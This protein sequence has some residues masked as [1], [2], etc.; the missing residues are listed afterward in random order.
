VFAFDE[1]GYLGRVI[2][3]DLRYWVEGVPGRDFIEAYRR[4][5]RTIVT[6]RLNL[7]PE[8]AQK[9]YDFAVTNAREENKYYRYDYFLDNCSTRVRD[10]IDFALGGALRRATQG[11]IVPRT[12][13]SETLRLVDDMKVTQFAINAA[14]ASPTDNELSV[15]ENMFV[16][17]RLKDAVRELRITDASGALVPAVADEQVLHE[18]QQHDERADAPSLWR[19]YLM[20][21]VLLAAQM[22]LVSWVG[23]RSRAADAS[24]RFEVGVWALLTGILGAVL[25]LGW[26]IT[27]HS[28]WYRNENLLLLNP[29]ALF[30]ATLAPLSLWRSRWARPAAISAVLLALLSAVALIVKGLP[31]FGQ[32]N[33]A[34][35][36][37]LL[38]PNFAVAFGLWLRARRMP[39]NTESREPR[40]A[41]R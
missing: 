7:T 24:F 15:W 41:S 26:M 40:A 14:L 31:W 39:P 13:R 38:P 3:N 20:V 23:V 8:Q 25:L 4:Y 33:L 5:D 21:G 11:T 28:F 17:S 6:Q 16:P 18:S 32:H 36:A 1:P 10:L 34:M 22:L 12:Y 2:V 37:L 30:L 35:I 9:A 27:R 19:G 29:L